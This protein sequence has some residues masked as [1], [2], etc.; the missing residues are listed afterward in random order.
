M[1]PESL[2]QHA[3]NFEQIHNKNGRILNSGMQ[4]SPKQKSFS[5]DTK[6][7]QNKKNG[8]A[9]VCAI[10]GQTQNTKIALDNIYP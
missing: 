2:N 1:A 4:Y 9:K 10:N 3:P 5:Q 8:I 6:E 7:L